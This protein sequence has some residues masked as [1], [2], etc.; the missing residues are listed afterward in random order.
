MLSDGAEKEI[1]SA[2]SIVRKGKNWYVDA[3]DCIITVN[4][5]VRDFK[6]KS[7]KTDIFYPNK[8]LTM[9]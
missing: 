3:G 5:T 9:A 8:H 4:P 1:E 7:L 2:D 6:Q